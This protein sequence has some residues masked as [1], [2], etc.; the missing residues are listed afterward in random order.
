MFLYYLFYTS[1]EKLARVHVGDCRH[2]NHG[3]G[4]SL[5]RGTRSRSTWSGPFA[6]CEEAVAQMKILNLRNSKTCSHC[7]PQDGDRPA[8]LIERRQWGLACPEATRQ[9]NAIPPGSARVRDDIAT[10]ISHGGPNVG[11]D[12][13]T[14]LA[15][16]AYFWSC[17]QHRQK[18]QGKKR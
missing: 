17:T 6:T 4:P 11:D 3:K 16:R 5:R 12:G 18:G 1:T 15:S 9:T 14:R 2:C 7:N 10:T 8:V 13:L